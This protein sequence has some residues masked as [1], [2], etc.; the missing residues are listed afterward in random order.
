MSARPTMLARD[1][2]RLAALRGSRAPFAALAAVL[3]LVN[4][5]L[6][7][8]VAAA[9][10][11]DRDA[12][13]SPICSGFDTSGDTIGLVPHCSAC[14]LAAGVVAPTR[15][16][17]AHPVRFE[18]WHPPLPVSAPT[19]VPAPLLARTAPRGPPAI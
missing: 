13:G 9:T 10:M 19:P 17:I 4:L 8:A 14:Q 1:G 3:M 16:T 11:G 18:T 7:T 15:P 5:L 12:F 6:P 2:E